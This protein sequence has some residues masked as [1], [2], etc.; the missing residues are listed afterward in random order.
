MQNH[1]DPTADSEQAAVTRRCDRMARVHD[2][3]DRPSVT[4]R[5]VW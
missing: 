1:A 4:A 3:Q 2:L 5:G